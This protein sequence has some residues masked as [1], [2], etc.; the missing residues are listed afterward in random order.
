MK[1]YLGFDSA[2]QLSCLHPQALALYADLEGPQLVLRANLVLRYIL[3]QTSV[4]FVHQP[5][6]ACQ[7][8]WVPI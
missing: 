6:A 8:Y 5:L 3:I 2:C 7:H 4:G 1:L